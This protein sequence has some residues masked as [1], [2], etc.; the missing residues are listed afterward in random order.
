MEAEAEQQ[1]F[2]QL[3]QGGLGLGAVK[4]HGLGSSSSGAETGG[5]CGAVRPRAGHCRPDPVLAPSQQVGVEEEEG[6]GVGRP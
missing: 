3:V 2:G 1:G 4:Q 6:R 5:R